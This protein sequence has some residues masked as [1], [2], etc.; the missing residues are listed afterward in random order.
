MAKKSRLGHTTIQW[1]EQTEERARRMAEE[2][3]WTLAT[4]VEVA[5]RQMDEREQAGQRRMA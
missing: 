1:S 4:L 5:L 2:R 3:R